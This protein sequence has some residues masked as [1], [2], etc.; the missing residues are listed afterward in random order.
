MKGA[1]IGSEVGFYQGCFYVW[2][3][4]L[5]LEATRATITYVLS[6]RHYGAARTWTW[7]CFEQASECKHTH[8]LMAVVARTCANCVCLQRSRKQINRVVRRAARR[9]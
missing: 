3:Q 9:I 8:A 7:W 6:C 5:Q 1:E 2:H 4:M